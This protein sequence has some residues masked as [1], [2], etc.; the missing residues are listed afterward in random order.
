M[1][2]LKGPFLNITTE[3]GELLERIDL[4]EYDLS[5]PIACATLVN[6][7]RQTVLV[8]LRRRAIARGKVE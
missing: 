8:V 3:D 4:A 6:E 2:K 1:P 7:I 5:K